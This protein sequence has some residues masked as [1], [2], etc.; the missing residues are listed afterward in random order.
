LSQRKILQYVNTNTYAAANSPIFKFNYECQYATT[1]SL[2]LVCYVA[3]NDVNRGQKCN[4]D[5]ILFV[6]FKQSLTYRCQK[7]WVASL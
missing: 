6:V 7:T 5:V 1:D 3:H 4:Y 2:Y